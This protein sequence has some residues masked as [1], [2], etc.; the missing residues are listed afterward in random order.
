MNKIRIKNKLAIDSIDV[1]CSHTIFKLSK[2]DNSYSEFGTQMPASEFE[3]KLKNIEGLQ[4]TNR[5]AGTKVLYRSH[6]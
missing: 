2:L 5:P 3:Q 1:W 4:S 6:F